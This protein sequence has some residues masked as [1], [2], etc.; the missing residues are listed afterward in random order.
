MCQLSVMLIVIV[1]LVSKLQ[2]LYQVS[3]LLVLNFR[4]RSLLNLENDESNHANKVKNTL[5]F[6]SFV[7]CQVILPC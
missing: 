3:I 5:L 1:L 2:T 4:G 6:N 7:L